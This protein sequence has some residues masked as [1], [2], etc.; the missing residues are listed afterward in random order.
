M[1]FKLCK[2]E[3]IDGG[4]T[5]YW[6]V[7]TISDLS[8]LFTV[9]ATDPADAQMLDYYPSKMDDS[10]AILIDT[11]KIWRTNYANSI[12]LD[13]FFMKVLGTTTIKP[14]AERTF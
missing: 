5:V 8:L 13:E 12:T 6:P 4:Y 14:L 3:F 7:G 9:S 1:G 2:Y 11:F 10:K